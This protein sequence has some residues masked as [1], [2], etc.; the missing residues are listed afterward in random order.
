MLGA[1]ELAI[2]KFM[3]YLKA[4]KLKLP[5][6]LDKASRDVLQAGAKLRMNG[7]YE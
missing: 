3:Y 1:L 5:K 6:G 2:A 4:E 7:N